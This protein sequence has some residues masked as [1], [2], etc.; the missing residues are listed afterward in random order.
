MR[1]WLQKPKTRNWKGVSDER[2]ALQ[3][4]KHCPSIPLRTA[5]A[6]VRHQHADLR[7]SSGSSLSSVIN[8]VHQ[9]GWL[10][11]FL[12]MTMKITTGIR[13]EQQQQQDDIVINFTRGAKTSAMSPE[14]FYHC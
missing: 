2:L 6:C 9:V 12:G 7:V 14:S 4:D 1:A 3:E 11:N 5:T 10:Q 8:T 13:G